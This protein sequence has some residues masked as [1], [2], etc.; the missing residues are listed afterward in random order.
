MMSEGQMMV[1]AATYA[2]RLQY[3]REKQMPRHMNGAQWEREM[4]H[5]A[6]E[7]AGMAVASLSACDS[8]FKK[9]FGEHSQAYKMLLTMQGLPT[10]S[11]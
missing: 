3:W 10:E 5:D 7:H 1:W 8:S 4:I 9:G 6:M 2:A 11:D